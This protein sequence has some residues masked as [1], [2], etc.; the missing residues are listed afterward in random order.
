MQGPQLAMAILFAQ[1][2]S[3]FILGGMN[4]SSLK[5]AFA[6]ITAGFITYSLVAKFQNFLLKI[7]KDFF[8]SVFKFQIF[9]NLILKFENILGF[10]NLTTWR[11]LFQERSYRDRGPPRLQYV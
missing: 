7:A 1:C 10:L 8:A 2:A 3:H 5:M 11:N 4:N 9:H 6:H